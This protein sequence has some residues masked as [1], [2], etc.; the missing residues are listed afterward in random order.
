[1]PGPRQDCVPGRPSALTFVARS[2]A[3]RSVVVSSAGGKPVHPTSRAGTR[4]TC[5]PVRPVEARLS[6]HTGDRGGIFV[7]LRILLR[8]GDVDRWSRPTVVHSRRRIQPPDPAAEPLISRASPIVPAARR[9]GGRP[10]RTTPITPP[11]WGLGEAGLCQDR[12]RNPPCGPGRMGVGLRRVVARSRRGDPTTK[13]HHSTLLGC[14][15]TGVRVWY[16]THTRI[17]S[18]AVVVVGPRMARNGEPHRDPVG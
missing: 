13:V 6:R 14:W 11:A 12:A 16:A 15:W 5:R 17:A 4:R 1:M 8:Y 3:L 18:A 10:T 9:D 7:D 2:L